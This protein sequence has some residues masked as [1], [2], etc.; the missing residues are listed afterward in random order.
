MLRYIRESHRD[1]PGRTL[2][3][4]LLVLFAL[5]IVV[6]GRR[7]AGREARNFVKLSPQVSMAT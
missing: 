7:R 5:W 4:V 2:L 3:E 1:D 6:Q